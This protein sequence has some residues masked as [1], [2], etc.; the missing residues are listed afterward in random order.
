MYNSK[1][2]KWSDTESFR[3]VGVNDSVQYTQPDNIWHGIE[4]RLPDLFPD[5]RVT[6]GVPLIVMK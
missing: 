1:P 2:F 6:Y 3:F 5:D 4:L